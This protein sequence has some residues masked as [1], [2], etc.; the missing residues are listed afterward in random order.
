MSR[1]AF[2]RDETPASPSLTEAAT[3]N[4]ASHA[5]SAANPWEASLNIR[6]EFTTVGAGKPMNSTRADIAPLPRT[7]APLAN[8]GNLPR[9]VYAAVAGLAC[10]PIGLLWDISHHSTIGRDTFW[11]PAHIV[12]Q[13]GGIMPA[14]L[15]ASIALKTTFRGTQQARA[16]SVSLYGLRAPLGVWVTIWVALAL[17]ASAPFDDWWHNRY[18][19]DVKI[20]SP[21]HAVLG[22]GMF[23][24]AMGV[25][26]FVFSSQNRSHREHRTRSGW[27]CAVAV[28]VMIAMWR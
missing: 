9:S 21:T 4:P 26:L 13:L 24:V 8:T 11:T 28:G 23:G 3:N 25:L 20:V 6:R 14:L 15:F 5:R 7:P 2:Y 10:L 1:W 16:A 27:L 19:L 18:G 12:I 17:M 22:M